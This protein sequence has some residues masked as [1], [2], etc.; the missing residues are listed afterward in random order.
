[1]QVTQ[2]GTGKAFGEAIMK[3]LEEVPNLALLDG[4]LASSLGATA[5]CSHPRFY[6]VHDG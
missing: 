6:Q 3:K 4:D 1:L 2:V 5:A